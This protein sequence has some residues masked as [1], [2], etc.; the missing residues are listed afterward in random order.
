MIG[1]GSSEQGLPTLTESSDPI[2]QA[3]QNATRAIGD[4]QKPPVSPPSSFDQQEAQYRLQEEYR[5]EVDKTRLAEL[6]AKLVEITGREDLRTFLKQLG[7]TTGSDRLTLLYRAFSESGRPLP[8]LQIDSN[9]SVYAL[10]APGDFTNNAPLVEF[11]RVNV[12][13][14]PNDERGT[15][16]LRDSMKQEHPFL[17]DNTSFYGK[18]LQ[19]GNYEAVTW[20]LSRAWG[21]KVFPHLRAEFMVN[22]VDDALT[23]ITSSIAVPQNSTPVPEI[24]K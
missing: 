7:E 10:N 8:L 24:P 5:N 21:N 15:P 17:A 12:S 14:T 6:N 22:Y 2:T 9:G 3:V 23:K 4:R 19:S 16:Y 20:E 1:D 18:R 13:E 11:K